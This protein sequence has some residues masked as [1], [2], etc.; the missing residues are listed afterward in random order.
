MPGVLDSRD[1]Q[2]SRCRAGR[3]SDLAPAAG[4][5]G[6]DPV[7]ADEVEPGRGHRGSELL[8]LDV[9]ITSLGGFV[10]LKNLMAFDF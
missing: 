2:R 9:P 6:E 7:V 1:E 3:G 8:R 5:R 4:G 10:Y